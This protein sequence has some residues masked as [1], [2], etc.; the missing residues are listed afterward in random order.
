MKHIYTFFSKGLLMAVCLAAFSKAN[1]QSSST[2]APGQCGI[3]VANFNNNSGNHASPSLYGDLFDSSFYY[4]PIRGYWTDMD[5]G[6]TTPPQSPR[7]ITIISPPYT[8]P[9]APGTFNVGFYYIVPRAVADR[10]QI[11]IV[12]VSPGPGGTTTSNIVATSG[13]KTFSDWSSPAPY[14]DQTVTNANGTSPANPLLTG[15]SGHVCIKILDADI[16]ND[17]GTFYR[18]E[19]AYVLS[20]PGFDN[21]FA[22]YDNLSIGQSI[23]GGSL[24]VNFIGIVGNRANDQAVNVRWDVGDEVDVKEYQVERSTTGGSFST[25]GIV[26]A[27]K[28]SVYS[29]TDQSAKAAVLYY[30]IKSVDLNGATKYSGIIKVNGNSSFSNEL[31]VYPSPAQ[32]QITLQHNQLFANAKVTIS[33]MDGRLLKTVTPG[34]GVSNTMV[35]L[36]GIAA[37]MYVLRVDNGNG[38]IETTTFVKQ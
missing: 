26:D 27:H 30:R 34:A 15:D 13:V 12:A 5:G 8:N 24:P 6:R 33:T 29:Y 20:S 7:N 28:K 1:A 19:I 32:S 17:P 16:T 25:I 11:R 38:K 23:G 18:V 21:F 9:S 35:D 2:T 3:V 14:V 4:N 10:F 37:G 36:S 22:V 31:K